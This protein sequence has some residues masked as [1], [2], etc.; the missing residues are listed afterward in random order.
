MN[1]SHHSYYKNTHSILFYTYSYYLQLQS[2]VTLVAY[3]GEQWELSY[4]KT[5]TKENVT[6][7]CDFMVVASGEFS[8]PVIPDIDRL[9]QYKGKIW[10]QCFTVCIAMLLLEL[11]LCISWYVGYDLWV[12][13][14]TIF[15]CVVVVCEAVVFRN[16]DLCLEANQYVYLNK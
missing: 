11:M 12:G 1:R 2:L 8:S 10:I 14:F 5:D 4:M 7:L 6:E 16:T 15:F 9:D 3:N 13:F